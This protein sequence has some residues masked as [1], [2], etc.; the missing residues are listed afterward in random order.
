MD[1]MN[2]MDVHSVHSVHSVHFVHFG[3][4]RAKQKPSSVLFS[5]ALLQRALRRSKL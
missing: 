5:R 2:R 1:W 4:D 3:Q